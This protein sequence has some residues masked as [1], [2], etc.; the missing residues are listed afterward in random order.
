MDDLPRITLNISGSIG[1]DVPLDLQEILKSWEEL[2]GITVEIRQT[3]WAAYLQDLYDKRYQMFLIGWVSDFPDPENYLDILFHSESGYNHTNY[4]NPV[5][6]RLL[7]E[8]REIPDQETRFRQYNQ[9]EQMILDDAP[10]IPLWNPG[11]R[12]ALIKPQVKDYLLDAD[13]HSQV[14]PRLPETVGGLGGCQGRGCIRGS[15]GS[16]GVSQESSG[17]SE[18]SWSALC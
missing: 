1:D 8:A 3:E 4:N 15:V 7:E 13:A 18:T 5:V 11:E 10:L 6:D 16:S 17:S 14:P 2:L 12:Y 9:I